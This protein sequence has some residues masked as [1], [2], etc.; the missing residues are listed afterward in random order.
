[1]EVVK[2]KKSARGN[3]YFIYNNNPQAAAT[4]DARLLTVN[5]KDERYDVD[6]IR[7]RF[8]RNSQTTCRTKAYQLWFV[9]SFFTH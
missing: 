7:S 9:R 3:P 2:L 4:S 5:L 8:R 6:I 1:M